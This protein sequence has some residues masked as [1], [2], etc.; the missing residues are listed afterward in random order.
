[1]P[2]QE[3]L[4]KRFCWSLGTTSFRTK[5][6]NLRIERQLQLLHDIWESEKIVIGAI[7]LNSRKIIMN[8]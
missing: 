6:F 4:Y 1:M 2:E 3:L 7:I 5:N 8:L